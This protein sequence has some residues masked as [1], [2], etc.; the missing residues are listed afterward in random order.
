M[1]ISVLKSK[2]H[3]ARITGADLDYEGSLAIDLDLIAAAGLIPYE[4]ILIVNANNAE[5]FE[6]YVIPAPAGTRTICLN[7]AASRLGMRGDPITIMAFAEVT[8]AEAAELKPAII[9]LDD[10]N[11]IVR[12]SPGAASLP[13]RP[14]GRKKSAR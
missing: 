6:T 13:H 4:R 7:G 10:T 11:Q 9:I 1:H 2:I 8:P 5:R 14:S 12:R 3:R